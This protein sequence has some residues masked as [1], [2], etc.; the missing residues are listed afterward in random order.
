MCTCTIPSKHMSKEGV[1]KWFEEEIASGS[2]QGG[3]EE[4]EK[5]ER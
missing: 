2:F 5:G 4:V 1:A 3:E